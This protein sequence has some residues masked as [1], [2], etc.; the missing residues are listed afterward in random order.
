MEDYIIEVENVSKKYRL[1]QIGGTTLREELQRK[2]AKLRGR[3]DPTVKIGTDTSKFG[4]EFFALN[5]VSFEVRRGEKVGIIGHNGAGKSTL[6]KLLA[7]ITAP[8]T[9]CIGFDGRI[10]SMLE[11]GTGFNG[12]LTGRENIY[13]N[14][15]ILGMKEKE[16]EKKIDEIIKFSECEQFIDTPVKRYSSGMFVKLAFAVAAHLDSEIIIMDEVLAVGDLAFQKKCI[17][18]MNTVSKEENRTIL[19]VSHNMST[20]RKLCDRCIVLEKGKI[21]FDGDVEKA[22]AIYS[23]KNNLSGNDISFEDVDRKKYR[24][25]E[26]I[27]F[28]RLK[29]LDNNEPIFKYNSKI[30]MRLYLNA[31]KEI[32]TAYLRIAIRTADGMLIGTA[33]SKKII[34]V[35]P[36]NNDI[37]VEMECDNLCPGIYSL[38]LVM[39]SGE[40]DELYYYHDVCDGALIFEIV[41]DETVTGNAWNATHFGNIEFSEVQ[42]IQ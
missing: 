33:F 13:M 12:E 32:D 23:G 11:V 22:I 38:Q 31:K 20:I 37:E 34:K 42:V 5:D 39:N 8:T 9:G 24:I 2:S 16:I 10:T 35:K 7:R 19:Y 17:D 6:L 18:K 1:G 30:K 14:G 41:N 3:E 25:D 29:L 40:T 27:T 21:I 15:A 26:L 28:T 36:G 4:E